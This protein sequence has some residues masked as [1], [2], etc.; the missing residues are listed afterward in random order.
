MSGLLFFCSFNWRYTGH[1]WL[2][3][4]IHTH[5]RTPIRFSN[6]QRQ[7]WWGLQSTT[8]VQSKNEDPKGLSAIRNMASEPRTSLDLFDPWERPRGEDEGNEE[9]RRGEQRENWKV[10]MKRSLTI[11]VKMWNER[12]LDWKV[13]NRAKRRNETGMLVRMKGEGWN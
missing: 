3:P 5:A 9:R 11:D 7:L 13:V 4:V 1:L 2:H 12:T 6:R 8:K 10:M